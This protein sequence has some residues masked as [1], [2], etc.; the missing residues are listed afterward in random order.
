MSKEPGNMN[1]Q[2]RHVRPL[3][4]SLDGNVRSSTARLDAGQVVIGAG[5]VMTG[6][7]SNCSVLEVLGHANGEFQAEKVQVHSGGELRGTVE[8]NEAVV[9][10]V[11][12]GTVSVENKL[13]IREGGAVSGDLTYGELGVEPGGSM[14]G[15]IGLKGAP[16]PKAAAPT[17]QPLVA[18]QP[19]PLQHVDTSTEQPA[20]SGT[21]LILSRLTPRSNGAGH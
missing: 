19:M 15:T 13:D 4:Q 7:V 16:E 6:E 11:L 20:P 17:I 9:S 14:T 12:D 18:G 5:A 8:T 1:A 10:G 21:T 3:G 2:Q